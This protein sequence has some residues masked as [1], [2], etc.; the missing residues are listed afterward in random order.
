MDSQFKSPPEKKTSHKPR[1][2]SVRAAAA[3]FIPISLHEILRSHSSM[4]NRGGG[5]FGGGDFG[6]TKV[7]H[8]TSKPPKYPSKD[9][10][11]YSKISKIN[12]GCENLSWSSWPDLGDNSY[13]YTYNLSLST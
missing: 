6:G 9:L 7:S 1:K 11:S 13:T 5:D 10:L 4:E 2:R 3:A 12:Y 8:D